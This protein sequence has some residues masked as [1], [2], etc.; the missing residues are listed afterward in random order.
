MAID[1][2]WLR[3]TLD[4]SRRDPHAMICTHIIRGG[5][6]CIGPF[7]EDVDTACGLWEPNERTLA[8]RQHLRR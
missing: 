5:A 1:C 2:A 6:D 3:R 7:L 4:A 8:L